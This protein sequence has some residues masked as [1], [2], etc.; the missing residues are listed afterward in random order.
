MHARVIEQ[1]LLT[2]EFSQLNGVL[3]V[4]RA[5]FGELL[6]D[7]NG[8]QGEAIL[9][10]LVADSLEVIRSLIVVPHA[11]VK[12]AHG[13]QYGG[14][15][16]VF[17]KDLFVFS[18]SVGKLALLDKLLRLRQDLCF[19]EAKPKCHKKSVRPKGSLSKCRGKPEIGAI[20]AKVP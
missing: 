17:L 4:V 16:G 7:S 20:G 13:I 11:R 15:L 6:V 14:V 10:V 19:I 3:C 18:D 2:I 1:T 9:R 5:H 8:L 12:I